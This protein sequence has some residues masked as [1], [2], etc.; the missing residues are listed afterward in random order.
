MNGANEIGVFGPALRWRR[1]KGWLRENGLTRRFALD[2]SWAFASQAVALPASLLET[3][4]LARLLGVSN[5][6]L[7]MVAVAVVELVYG[8]L[9][10]RSGEVV[11]KYLPELRGGPGNLRGGAL[12]RAVILIDALLAALGLLII[13]PVIQFLGGWL[14][15][16]REMLLP[17]LIVGIGSG[18]KLT[19]GSVGAYLRVMKRFPLAAQLGMAGTAIRILL[20]IVVVSWARSVP[21]ACFALAGA[22]T[23]MFL[24]LLA[25]LR[26]GLKRDAL[27]L[28]DW[29]ERLPR[30]IFRAVIRFMFHTNLSITVRTLAKKGDVLLIAALSSTGVVALYKIAQRIAG[31]LMLVSDPL[32]TVVYPTLSRYHAEGRQMEIRKLL[33]LLTLGLA[34]FALLFLIGF[35][36][37]G[38]WLLGVAAGRDFTA[39]FRASMIMI[40]GS[41][42]S[43]TFFWLRPILLVHGLTGRLVII[44]IVATCLK[45]AVLFA[46]VPFLGLGGA[47]WSYVVYSVVVVVGSLIPQKNV[48]V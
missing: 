21:G 9:D 8:V 18:L 19:M 44:G 4:L 45:F 43:M 37:C 38:Q 26:Y 27:T 24:L 17:C 20:L 11:I 1:A 13:L 42:L 6:G 3:F 29:S 33:R 40:G 25:G 31:S 15:V 28:F 48:L 22:D 35:G 30:E 23:A 34:S 46:F 36:L 7:L 32:V 12:L 16:P 5:F 41:L 10:C 47:A 2:S 14:S 39:S